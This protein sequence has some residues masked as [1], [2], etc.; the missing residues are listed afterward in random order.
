MGLLV[1]FGKSNTKQGYQRAVSG[2]DMADCYSYGFLARHA[3]MVL[4]TNR[5]PS[6]G[7][8]LGFCLLALRQVLFAKIKRDMYGG[9]RLPLGTLTWGEDHTMPREIYARREMLENL[10]SDD[11]RVSIGRMAE[12]TSQ[13]QD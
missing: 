7:R 13:K 11:L 4:R 6:V 3:T 12:L 10:M 2:A 8:R 1:K 5:S 9:E